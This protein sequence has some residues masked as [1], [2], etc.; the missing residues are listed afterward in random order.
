MLSL[1]RD[2][3][4]E[5]LLE[6]IE[7]AA[8]TMDSMVQRAERDRDTLGGRIVDLER[9]VLAL[10]HAGGNLSFDSVA[11]RY[12]DLVARTG[13]IAKSIVNINEESPRE[14]SAL[15]I[16][17]KSLSENL[18]KLVNQVRNEMAQVAKIAPLIKE[19]LHLLQES[20]IR[21]QIETI[22]Q[23]IRHTEES[24]AAN[25]KDVDQ[26]SVELSDVGRL[27][28]LEEKSSET[29]RRLLAEIRSVVAGDVC[30]VC[31]RPIDRQ[32]LLEIIDKRI[33]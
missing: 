10:R 2:D 12:Q 13:S 3:S 8:S 25:K 29:T 32:T 33:V 16:R 4:S 30:P 11:T 22:A 5:V 15:G 20:E 31:E 14:V 7:S 23:A 6:R 1:V 21:Q 27:L 19:G 26:R 18:R 28:Q 24:L 17:A 9:D